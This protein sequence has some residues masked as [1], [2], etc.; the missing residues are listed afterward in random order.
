MISCYQ[1][2]KLISEQL[3]HPLSLGDKALLILHLLNCWRCKLFANQMLIIGTSI[4]ELADET[5]AF[6]RSHDINMPKL[7]ARAKARVRL[8]IRAKF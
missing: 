3:D 7:N 6:K 1:A 8:S 2:T 5:R 4:R